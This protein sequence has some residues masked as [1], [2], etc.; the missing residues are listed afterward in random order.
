MN[1][2]PEDQV[3]GLRKPDQNQNE[4]DPSAVSTDSSEVIR[5]RHRLTDDISEWL[6]GEGLDGRGRYLPSVVRAPDEEEHALSPY[7]WL[8]LS[9][10]AARE[11]PTSVV[12]LARDVA[13]HLTE[14]PLESVSQRMVQRAFI[15]LH[16]YFEELS[17][18]G[19]LEYCEDIGTVELRRS[20]VH[21]HHSK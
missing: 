18:D 13:A 19:Y 14:R 3:D 16:P 7:H 5:T 12:I 6:A 8:I 4:H 10:L 2:Y 20:K 9:R 21:S 11:G 1:G 15:E 17:K